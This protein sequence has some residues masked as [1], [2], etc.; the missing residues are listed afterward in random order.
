MP[1][2]SPKLSPPGCNHFSTPEQL[3]Q[4]IIRGK[5]EQKRTKALKII[6]KEGTPIHKISFFG[7]KL[8]KW[9]H[10]RR[11]VGRPRMNWTEETIREVWDKLKQDDERY[12]FT[13]F[14][15][16]NEEHIKHIKHC[17]ANT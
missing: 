12:R 6:R 9:I 14:D 17:A 16:E 10:P 3:I 4:I 7:D 2:K 1:P 13:A 11:R 15:G 8:R 5:R